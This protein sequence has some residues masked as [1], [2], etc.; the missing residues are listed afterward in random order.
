[1]SKGED[2]ISLLDKGYQEIQNIKDGDKLIFQLTKLTLKALEL[3]NMILKLQKLDEIEKAITTQEQLRDD[4]DILEILQKCDSLAV[5][6]KLYD[7]DKYNLVKAHKR[8]YEKI[9][10][11]THQY[12]PNHILLIEQIRKVNNLE[13]FKV[14]QKTIYEIIIFLFNLAEDSSSFQPLFEYMIKALL[15]TGCKESLDRTF[16]A[17]LDKIIPKIF[18]KRDCYYIQ[19]IMEQIILS[20]QYKHDFIDPSIVGRAI[21]SKF[22]DMIQIYEYI[23]P[24]LFNLF[25]WNLE[26]FQNLLKYGA[27][28]QVIQL[29]IL[30]AKS[31]SLGIK[32]KNE[33]QQYYQGLLNGFRENLLPLLNKSLKNK[34]CLEDIINLIIFLYIS[35]GQPETDKYIKGSTKYLELLEQNIQ[36]LQKNNDLSPQQQQ[37]I[38]LLVIEFN[39]NKY[40]FAKLKPQGSVYQRDQNKLWLQ[41]QSET[42]VYEKV[43]LRNLC[44]TCYLN[45]FLQSL[46]Y[47]DKFRELIL[48]IE[49]RQEFIPEQ[50]NLHYELKRAFIF[51]ATQRKVI[52]YCPIQ[53][54]KSFREPYK[55]AIEQQDA[56]EFGAH[57]F[58]DFENQFNKADYQK[59]KKMFI[60]IQK[61]K[62]IC[63]SNCQYALDGPN[64]EFLQLTLNF[65]KKNYSFSSDDQQITKLIEL[66]LEE[67]LE[68]T[69]EKC[70]KTSQGNKK[71]QFILLPEYLIIQL[72]RF[73][74]SYGSKQ[75]N[76]DKVQLEHEIKLK[77]QNKELK[78]QLYSIII[79]QGT[80][81]EAGHYISYSCIN[82]KWWKF[83]DSEVSEVQSINIEFRYN[84]TP[85]ILFYKKA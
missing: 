69:C 73:I 25:E 76:M 56:G 22:E 77:E 58:D 20:V 18:L 23:G 66:Y 2:I 39:K 26:I 72:N 75:K 9:R 14:L 71:M 67:K 15:L 65:T 61:A 32:D 38:S 13:D 24:F 12:N 16:L 33:K 85:Y 30:I 6:A 50:F 43:G 54:K 49:S 1:M 84:M 78:Y 63:G 3:D 4:R 70:K 37:S 31:A 64:E 53:L 36:E 35:P 17:V 40:P 27:C 28:K 57:L 47:T 46:Y 80:S 8:V 42:V 29:I 55:S 62:F 48:S 68:Y 7:N 5:L 81:S 51:L 44:N 19:I 59:V 45:S 21:I 79:H 74:F 60:G 41:I 11:F 34:Y 10:T 83:D 82:N 52:D